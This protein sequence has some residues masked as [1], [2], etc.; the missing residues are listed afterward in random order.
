MNTTELEELRLILKTAYKRRDKEDYDEDCRIKWLIELPM[1][2]SEYLTFT[3]VVLGE[4][5]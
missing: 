4:E 2:H 5:R 3:K 1:T